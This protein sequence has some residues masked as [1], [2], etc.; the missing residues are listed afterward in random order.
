M[1]IEVRINVPGYGVGEG[2]GTEVVTVVSGRQCA[3][4]SL[5]V[6]RGSIESVD[7]FRHENISTNT[8]VQQHFDVHGG[9]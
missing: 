1:K 7:A 5:R 4:G 9:P 2:G 8:R 3:K 6:S